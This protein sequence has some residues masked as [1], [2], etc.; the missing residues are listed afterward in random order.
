MKEYLQ[1]AEKVYN[2]RMSFSKPVGMWTAE[3]GGLH[4][5]FHIWQ[6]GKLSQKQDFR[7]SIL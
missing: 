7:N 1:M 2:Y 3:I 6:Y 4:R 5:V